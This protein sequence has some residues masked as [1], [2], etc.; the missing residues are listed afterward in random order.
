MVL[1]SVVR[2]C[3]SFLLPNMTEMT[4]KFPDIIF[5]DGTYRSKDKK[6]FCFKTAEEMVK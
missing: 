6:L 5:F 1:S 3:E 4:S 2:L